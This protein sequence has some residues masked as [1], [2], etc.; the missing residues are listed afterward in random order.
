MEKEFLKNKFVQIRTNRRFDHFKRNILYSAKMNMNNKNVIIRI[1]YILYIC[2]IREWFFSRDTFRQNFR[3]VS[4][5]TI[6]FIRYRRI[7]LDRI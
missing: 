2:F 3:I 6:F 4:K 1:I 5:C 7:I